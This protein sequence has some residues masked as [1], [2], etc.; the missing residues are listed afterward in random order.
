MI[1]TVSFKNFKALRDLTMPLGRLTVLVGPNAS[2]KTSVLQGVAYLLAEE[3]WWLFQGEREPSLLRTQGSS[4]SVELHCAGVW[5]SKRG[6]IEL[7]LEEVDARDWFTHLGLTYDDHLARRSVSPDEA[8]SN[9]LF[10]ASRQ[11]VALLRL[12]AT[13][14]AEASYSSDLIPGIAS[15]G[16]GV[17]AVLAEMRVSRPDDF[18]RVEQALSAVV[19]YVSGL[20]LERAPVRLVE[21]EEVTVGG[22]TTTY[23]REREYVGHRVVFEM[24]GAPSLR[25]HLASEGTLITLGL[26]VAIIESRNPRLLLIDD[27]ERAV[28]PRALADL[29]AQLRKLIESYPDL[30]IIATSHSPYL[31]D[32]LDPKEVRLMIA[33][34]SGSARW[35]RLEDHP[36]YA[37]WREF[38]RPGEIWS[39]V[40]EDWVK[41]DAAAAHG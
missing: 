1:E 25:A 27:I 10:R 7:L 14:V 31:V 33:D 2:G 37:R 12:D 40:G 19:P 28:H 8:K 41:G 15:D 36:D 20:R 23:A 26:L 32:L 30:Q 38:M 18:R 17:A 21:D 11:R 4:G 16:V 13:K 5:N 3:P 9:P 29:V 6:E 34:E 24:K 39:M 35:A 22:K